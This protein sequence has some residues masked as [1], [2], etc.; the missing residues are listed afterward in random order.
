MPQKDS[1]EPKA[2]K[3]GKASNEY[4]KI[5]GQELK[6]LRPNCERCGRGYFMADHG[7]RFTCGACGLTRYKQQI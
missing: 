5:E 2:K 7:D 1:E 6:R 3:K 4:Y